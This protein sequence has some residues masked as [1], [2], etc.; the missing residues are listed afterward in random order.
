[1]AD[2][3]QCLLSNEKQTSVNV[4]LDPT[5]RSYRRTVSPGELH[6][7]ERSDCSID[8][9][10]KYYESV[11]MTIYCNV[12]RNDLLFIVLELLLIRCVIDTVT[13]SKY[14]HILIS[15]K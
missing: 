15:K 11:F 10:F 8:K 6:P 2:L 13:L 9:S 12:C 5:W 14:Q 7:I 4:F 3:R 1:M